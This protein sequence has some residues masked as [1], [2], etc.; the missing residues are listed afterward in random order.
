MTMHR[1]HRLEDVADIS[2]S[3]RSCLLPCCKQQSLLRQIQGLRGT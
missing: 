3:S 1:V 2:S